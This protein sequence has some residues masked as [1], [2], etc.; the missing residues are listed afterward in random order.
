MLECKN[1]CKN[2]WC[3]VTGINICDSEDIAILFALRGMQ[4]YK[5][6]N[7]R[8]FV[9]YVALYNSRCSCLSSIGCSINNKKPNYCKSYP[10]LMRGVIVLPANCCFA[11]IADELVENME[12]V[13]NELIGGL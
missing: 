13:T 7:N 9:G 8:R 3:C 6:K 1:Q 10:D 2:A 5:T 12:N 11:G 4:V